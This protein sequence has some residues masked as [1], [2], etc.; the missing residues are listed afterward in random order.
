MNTKFRHAQIIEQNSIKSIT[1]TKQRQKAIK[2]PNFTPAR[3]LNTY[4]SNYISG[5]KFQI[6]KSYNIIIIQL[7]YLV[8]LT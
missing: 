4:H 3:E 1:D 6:L 7:Q 8:S 2:S 5:P